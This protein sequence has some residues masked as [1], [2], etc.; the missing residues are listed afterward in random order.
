MRREDRRKKQIKIQKVLMLYMIIFV[1]AIGLTFSVMKIYNSRQP[2]KI[3]PEQINKIKDSNS[4]V[5]EQSELVTDERSTISSSEM[6]LD[7]LDDSELVSNAAEV[8]YGIYYFN[9]EKYI[10][11]HN[12]DPMISASVIKIFIM[13]YVY[14][15]KL[16]TETTA[17]GETLD[18]LI[19]QMIQTSDN[20]ATNTI[21]DHCGMDILNN[22]FR[23][24]GYTTTQL[25]RKMLD[26]QA[27]SMGKENYTS[28]EDTMSFLKK[29]YQNRSVAPYSNMLEMMRGQQIRTKIPSKLPTTVQVANKTG[30]L[31]SVEND[32]GLVLAE[33]NPFAIVIL[34]NDVIDSGQ[35]RAAI[36][37][38]T[39]VALNK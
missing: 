14:R 23:E 25:Q 16:E 29:V 37:N 4:T 24:N 33:N 38:F 8:S 21:I 1:L 17:T 20:Q 12:N 13:E 32:I 11:N 34:S 18:T 9:D 22:Y 6:M 3:V 35:M 10:S 27:R 28:L 39:L 30:E 31:P 26:E 7:S 5:S 36:G 15:K 2:A 19:Q